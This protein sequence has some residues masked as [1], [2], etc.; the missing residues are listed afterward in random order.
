MPGRKRSTMVAVVP[1]DREISCILITGSLQPYAVDFYR[2]LERAMKAQGWRLRILVGSRSTYRP[3]TG[4]EAADHDP[5]FLFFSGKPAPEWVQR[6]LGSSARDKI[7]LPGG[8]GIGELLSQHAPDILILNERNPLNLSAAFWARRHRVP[9][10]LSTDIGAAPPPHAATRFHLIYH[11]LIRGLFDGVI[12]KTKDGES[13]FA[14]AG[15]CAP[16][17]APHGIDSSRFPLASAAKAEPFRFLFVGALEASKGLDIL[18]EAARLLHQRGLGFVI[19]LVGSGSW[20]PS[21][22]DAASPWLSL[23]GFRERQELLAEYHAAS[24]FILPSKGDTYGVVV[25][26]AASCALPLLVSTATGARHTLVIEGESGFQFDPEDAATLADRMAA[27]I[28]DPA[29]CTRLGAKARELA[30]HWCTA[31]S[32]ERVAQWL[33]QFLPA[34]AS[35]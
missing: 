8:S 19:R 32:G 10:L 9:C 13:A 2:G 7:L 5:L 17:L 3:W 18:T 23:A 20:T 28:G 29:L 16:I 27:L 1:P 21:A 12:A 31:R 33:Q 26:E 30:L 6:L 34:P 35:V 25:H 11:R 22:E 14:K 24:A 4:L 15:A